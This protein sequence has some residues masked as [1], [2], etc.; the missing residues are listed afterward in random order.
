MYTFALRAVE[1]VA[2]A[3]TQYVCIGDGAA[4][5]AEQ[6]EMSMDKAS[7]EEIHWQAH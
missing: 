1:N 6:L 7:I 4:A 5:S 2:G 3:V